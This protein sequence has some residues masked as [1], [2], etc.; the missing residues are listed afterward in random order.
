MVECHIHGF[1]MAPKGMFTNT[2]R[3]FVQKKTALQNRRQS[4]GLDTQS[5]QVV[6]V[7][8]KLNVTDRLAL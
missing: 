4:L 5:C 8:E 1:A 7:I 3:I 6:M 2:Q